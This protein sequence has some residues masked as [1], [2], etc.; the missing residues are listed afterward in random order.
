MGC[1]SSQSSVRLAVYIFSMAIHCPTETGKNSSPRLYAFSWPCEC[2]SVLFCR[3]NL[4]PLMFTTS[5]QHVLKCNIPLP[6]VLFD[7]YIR[8]CFPCIPSN[9][10]HVSHL[11]Y[12][13]L[14][15]LLCCVVHG[16][17]QRPR[18]TLLGMDIQFAQFRP[19]CFWIG[20]NMYMIVGFIWTYSYTYLFTPF[21]P[22]FL[23]LISL[24]PQ[25]ALI[26]WSSTIHSFM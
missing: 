1:L 5:C 24:H 15:S 23:S 14:L 6:K 19:F 25:L 21:R 10:C 4:D 13:G 7:A 2:F 20:L 3:L 18:F 9:G 26:Y 12:L 22:W 17:K 11:L 16:E 8:R